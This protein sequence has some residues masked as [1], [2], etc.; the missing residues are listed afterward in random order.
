MWCTGSV[1]RVTEITQVKPQGR[2]NMHR[3]A[4]KTRKLMAL[5]YT[6]AQSKDEVSFEWQGL[7][8]EEKF[9]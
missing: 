8:E 4:Y 5:K 7:F 9:N 2:K 1:V 3:G 6:N